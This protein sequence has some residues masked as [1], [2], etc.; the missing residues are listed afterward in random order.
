MSKSDA[1]DFKRK[2]DLSGLALDSA[3]LYV[4]YVYLD[5]DERRRFAQ[6]SHEYL[7][8]QLQFTGAES[9]TQNATNYKVK[10][11]FNHPVKEL[12]WFVRRE[13]HT[14]S[15]MVVKDG[16]ELVDVSSE[17]FGQQHFNF[18]DKLDATPFSVNG[19]GHRMGNALGSGMT[20]SGLLSR[21]DD[22][23]NDLSV[24][25]NGDITSAWS[26]GG[27]G[28]AAAANQRMDSGSNPCV[29]AKLQLNGH[30]RFSTRSGDYFNY[31]QPYQHH[32]SSPAVGINVYS[33]ALK[34]EEHQPSG[35][36]NMSRID[37]AQ[38]NLQLTTATTEVTSAQI[39]VFAVNYNVLR[40]M[41]GMGGLAYSN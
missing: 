31:V 9:V 4:D 33:F 11:N 34:P 37:N 41:S 29:S 30:D 23:F 35:T 36:C 1:L 32:S 15:E 14:N 21:S 5:T 8:E 39:W 28:W 18:S 16:M 26:T 24:A 40:I 27:A 2:G 19:P 6:V 3:S 20:Q 12:V 22:D 13:N 7:I 25:A 10:L 17:V 38:L